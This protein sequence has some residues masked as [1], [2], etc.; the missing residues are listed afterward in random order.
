[1]IVTLPARTPV[2]LYDATGIAVGVQ[3][4]VT[5]VTPNDA[6]V[7]ESA[8]S[9]VVTDSHFPVTYRGFSVLSDSTPVGAWGLSVAGGSVDVKEAL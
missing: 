6:R 2:D 8:A 3:I 9:P 7:Y 5:N 4:I 1:M